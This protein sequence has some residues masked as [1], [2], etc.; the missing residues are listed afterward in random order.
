MVEVKRN[1]RLTIQTTVTLAE[2]EYKS[3]LRKAVDA[4][5]D[6]EVEIEDS[7]GGDINIRWTIYED[8]ADD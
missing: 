8:S 7:Y 2:A 3:I 1:T 5:T 4:P 6:A